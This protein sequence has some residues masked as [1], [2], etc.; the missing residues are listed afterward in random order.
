MLLLVE[1]KSVM[2]YRV[3]KRALQQ[4][5]SIWLYTDEVWGEK[6]AVKYIYGLYAAF[7]EICVNHDLWKAVSNKKLVGLYL[8]R[9]KKHLIF[10]KLLPSG[11][12]GIVSILHENMNLPERLISDIEESES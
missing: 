10:F 1:V 9:Y 11:E 2:R 4:L 8:Y 3:F 6:Q 5:S 7:S 12:V